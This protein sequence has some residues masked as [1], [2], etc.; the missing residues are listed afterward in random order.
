MSK[1][2][3]ADFY[4]ILETCERRLPPGQTSVQFIQH[5][6]CGLSFDRR[7][8]IAIYALSNNTRKVEKKYSEF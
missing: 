3:K 8:K 6:W 5:F 2:V 4:S 1:V 7:R